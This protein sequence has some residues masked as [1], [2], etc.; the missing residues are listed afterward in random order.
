MVGPLGNIIRRAFRLVRRKNAG[1]QLI[2]DNLPADVV[3]GL[4]ILHEEQQAYLDE[5]RQRDEEIDSA[6]RE[7]AKQKGR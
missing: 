2:A 7:L 4:E 1:F 3:A 6:K 5:R